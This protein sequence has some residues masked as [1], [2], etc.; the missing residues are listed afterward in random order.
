LFYSVYCHTH[1]SKVH[2]FTEPNVTKK[3]WLYSK[4]L[5]NESQKVTQLSCRTQKGL[6][7]FVTHCSC[8]HEAEDDVQTCSN[9]T[10]FVQYQSVK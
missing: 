10:I 1:L 7:G 8:V 5:W 4:C 3:F 6:C 9:W 2:F